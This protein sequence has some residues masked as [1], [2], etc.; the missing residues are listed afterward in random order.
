MLLFHAEE[1]GRK[2]EDED[3]NEGRTG[4]RKTTQALSKRKGLSLSRRFASL[5]ECQQTAFSRKA[6]RIHECLGALLQV[7]VTALKLFNFNVSIN[8]FIMRV[9]S[10]LHPTLI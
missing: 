7:N 3:K 5:P 9:V 2:N 4:A 10:P 8:F 1:Q 6:Q